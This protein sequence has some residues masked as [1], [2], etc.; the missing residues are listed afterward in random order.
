MGILPLC[1][2]ETEGTKPDRFNTESPV[3]FN[4]NL[5]NELISAK[6]SIKANPEDPKWTSTPAESIIINLIQNETLDDFKF[7]N[8]NKI[9]FKKL[10]IKL[11]RSNKTAKKIIEKHAPYLLDIE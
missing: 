9:N 5:K 11:K 1:Y 4:S 10:S 6:Y 2:K 7:E 8:I 3:A